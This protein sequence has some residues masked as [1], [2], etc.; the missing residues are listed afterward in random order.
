MLELTITL[1]ALIGGLSLIFAGL[2]F[3]SDYIVPFVARRPWRPA[4][5]AATYRRR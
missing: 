1:L 4:R 3:A 2:A 5:R